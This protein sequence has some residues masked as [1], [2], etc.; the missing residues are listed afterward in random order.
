[1]TDPSLHSRPFSA[2]GGDSISHFGGA[3]VNYADVESTSQFVLGDEE[4]LFDDRDVDASVRALRPRSS[5]RG[6]WESEASDW[7]AR[8]AYGS[9]SIA[10]ND[11]T[12][13]S[14]SIR[15]DA[16]NVES[17]KPEDDGETAETPMNTPPEEKSLN[18]LETKEDIKESKRKETPSLSTLPE[19]VPSAVEGEVP[20]AETQPTDVFHSVPTTPLASA[21]LQL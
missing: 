2:L 3:S 19:D 6:S 8:I 5:R 15:A 12:W 16:A 7:S 9:P 17:T 1:M 4:R 10:R 14:P 20:S 11:S 18:T 13:T 21:K